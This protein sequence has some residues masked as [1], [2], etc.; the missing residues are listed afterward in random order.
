M[1]PR[2]LLLDLDGTLVDTAPDM[3]ASLNR[4]LAEHGRAPVDFARA[5]TRVSDGVVGLVGLGF[6]LAADDPQL[7]ELRRRYLELYGEGVHD[8]SIIFHGFRDVLDNLDN[9]PWRWGVVTNK[10]VGLATPLLGALGLA[11]HDGCLVGG[12][13]LPRRKPHPDPLLHAARLLGVAPADCVYV[14]DAPRDIEAGRAAGMVTVAAR[15]GYLPDPAAVDAWNA[16]AVI[17]S[18]GE[19]VPLLRGLDAVPVGSAMR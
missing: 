10:P 14:G 5:R 1:T 9:P 6:G 13:S 19:L 3:V 11:P 4:L 2:A 17:D 16:D 12:D 15:Y 18:P 7:P 8:S